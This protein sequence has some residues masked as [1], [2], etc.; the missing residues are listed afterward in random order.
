MGTHPEIPY[1]LSSIW[2]RT[3]AKARHKTKTIVRKG[4]GSRKSVHSDRVLR[5]RKLF[6]LLFICLS[7]AV[8]FIYHCLFFWQKS[9]LS[10]LLL[11]VEQTNQKITTPRCVQLAQVCALLSTLFVYIPL[12]LFSLLSLFLLLPSPPASTFSLQSMTHKEPVVVGQCNRVGN[13]APMDKGAYG[14][15]GS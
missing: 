11:H 8:L 14:G 3:L 9:I 13:T 7:V 6:L 10:R 12:F 5:E 4:A 15:R 2:T 1:S